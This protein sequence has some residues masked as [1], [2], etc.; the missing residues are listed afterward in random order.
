MGGRCVHGRSPVRLPWPDRSPVTWVAR[1]LARTVTCLLYL[2]APS[3]SGRL[4]FHNR[5]NFPPAELITNTGMCRGGLGCVSF[6]SVCY[7]HVGM[8]G[9]DAEVSGSVTPPPAQWFRRYHEY[10]TKLLC[11]NR[12][13]IATPLRTSLLEAPGIRVMIRV[14]AHSLCSLRLRSGPGACG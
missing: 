7:I 2:Q 12:R 3:A 13:E 1:D 9:T 10:V 4:S 5:A 6:A 11:R 14:P 8:G